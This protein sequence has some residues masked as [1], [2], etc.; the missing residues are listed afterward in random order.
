[1]KTQKQ[2][3]EQL[4]NSDLH[5][6]TDPC[7]DC[8]TQDLRS[9]CNPTTPTPTTTTTPT[10]TIYCSAQIEGPLGSNLISVIDGVS[11]EETCDKLC[12]DEQMCMVYTYHP[13]NNPTLSETCYLLTA[14]GEPIREC[15]G[16]TCVSG[17]PNCE[18]SIC[19]FLEGG[20]MNPQL[21]GVLVTGEDKDIELLTLGTC[22][23]PVA[24]AI[25]GGGDTDDYGGGGGSGY[26][27]YT[28]NFPPKAYVKMA[29]HIGSESE[30]SYIR[31]SVV[32]NIIVEAR[33]GLNND[34]YNGGSGE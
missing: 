20:I 13:A 5:S 1:M 15:E 8:Q 12:Q 22:P 23:S 27:E 32:D 11:D 6:T 7:E 26:V 3:E 30:E 17:L 24:I 2:L 34:Y 18:G 16:D 28:T 29:V 33:S 21:Q 19:A 4:K 14:L 9:S 10:P 31:D 25:G